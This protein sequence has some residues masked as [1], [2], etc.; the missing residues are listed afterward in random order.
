VFFRSLNF[1][2]TIGDFRPARRTNVSEAGGLR[3]GQGK[4]K[5]PPE[6]PGGRWRNLELAGLLEIA[7]VGPAAQPAIA[8]HHRRD[9]VGG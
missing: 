2:M 9:G 4:Q 8:V 6:N 1:Q 5:R 7:S 3:I